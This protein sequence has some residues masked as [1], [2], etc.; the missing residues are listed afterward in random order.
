MVR[1]LWQACQ[2]KLPFTLLLCKADNSNHRPHT[3]YDAHHYYHQHHHHHH[4]HHSTIAGL[5]TT[6]ERKDTNL[7]KSSPI[8][9]LLKKCNGGRKLEVAYRGC[10][11]SRL[12]RLS[13][14]LS[15][16]RQWS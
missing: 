9:P 13:T 8:Y 6:T 1:L 5:I 2:Y 4:H 14:L 3:S 16:W 12:S 11:F 15:N 7:P 10:E